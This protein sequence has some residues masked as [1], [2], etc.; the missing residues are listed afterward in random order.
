MSKSPQFS[1]V[2][3]DRPHTILN[4]SFGI[5]LEPVTTIRSCTIINNILVAISS[6][7][8]TLT[9]CWNTSNNLIID[10]NINQP[11]NHSVSILVIYRYH[12]GKSSLFSD[13]IV[14][15]S[16]YRACTKNLWKFCQLSLTFL[17]PGH[18][19]DWQFCETFYLEHQIIRMI[20]CRWKSW[21]FLFSW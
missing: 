16:K 11:F 13:Q 6:V 10:I 17:W 21:Y 9:N 3:T 5:H 19:F 15:L 12:H 1:P 18:K 20:F 4:Y 8:L 2:Y 7:Y 14:R